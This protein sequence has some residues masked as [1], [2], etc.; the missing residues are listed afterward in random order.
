VAHDRRLDA[1]A[2]ATADALVGASAP[3]ALRPSPP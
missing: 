3:T 1:R 2:L